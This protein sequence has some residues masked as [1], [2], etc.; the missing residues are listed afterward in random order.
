MNG[1]CN[2]WGKKAQVIH[3][4]YKQTIAPGATAD[5]AIHTSMS[6]QSN[7]RVSNSQLKTIELKSI[8]LRSG[9]W[10]WSRHFHYLPELGLSF[11]WCATSGTT[12]LLTLFY[13]FFLAVLLFHR[14]YRDDQKCRLKY[15]KYWEEYC[16]FVPYKIIPFVY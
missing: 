9:F 1:D 15:G 6:Q 7:S 4:K 13:F 2:I 10:G 3:C 8:L 14:S 11:C 5:G 12:H 16:K